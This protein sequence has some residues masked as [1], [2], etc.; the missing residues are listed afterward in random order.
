MVP[1]TNI[2]TVSDLNGKY[3]IQVPA[4]AKELC[5]SYAGGNPIC[6]SIDGNNT[7]NFTV[8]SQV[9]DEVV[10]TALGLKRD[11]AKLG[12]A[13]E[14]LGA[15]D[16]SD[17]ASTNFLDNLS[18]QFAGVNVLSGPTGVGSTS[19]VSIR[20]NASFGNN[21]PLYVVDGIPIDN[22]S[23]LNV[24]NE[25]SQGFQ[26]V[27]F[28][29]GSP[30][31]SPFDVESV[32]VLKG[33]ASAA[34][35]GTRAANGVVIINTKTGKPSEGLGI[36]VNSQTMFERPFRLPQF[37]NE[38][39]QGNGG[40][41]EYLNGAGGGVNDNISFSY[42]PRLD[43]GTLTPQ[44]DSPVQL[45]DG[46]I[47]RAGDLALYD[48]E[49]ISPT[50]FNSNPDNVAD[51]YETGVTTTNNIAL[52][53]AFSGGNYRLSFT[54]LRSDSYI[55][56]VN[57]E[58][59]NVSA[60][61]NFTPTKK[62]TVSTGINYVNSRSDNR[63]SSG[64]GSENLN[65]TLVSWLGRSTNLES[66]RDYWQ[67]GL[68]GI[69]QFSFNTSFFDNPFFILNENR[70]S[71][72]RDRFTG[73]LSANY[74]IS[75]KL[76]FRIRTGIDNS[77]EDREF[78]RAFS[79]NRFRNGAYAENTVN[80]T[81]QNTDVLLTYS[82]KFKGITFSASVGGNRLNQ[83]TEFE[84]IQAEALSAPG[85][86]RL[87]NTAVPLISFGQIT[88]RRI[89]SVYGLASV[90][91]RDQIFVDVT[92]RNDW[93]SSLATPESADNTSFF[94]PSVSASWIASK[95]LDLTRGPIS[96][97]QLRAS[98]AQVGSDTDPYRTTGT[99]TASTPVGGNPAF[100]SQAQLPA[101]GLRPERST[102]FEGGVDV[103]VLDDKIG[104][105]LTVYTQLNKD[106]ILNLPSPISSGYESRIV[107]GGAVRATGIEAVLSMRN[108]KLGPIRYDGRINFTKSQATVERLPDGVDR[109]TIDFARVYSSPGQT[110]FFIAEEGSKI[111]DIFGTGYLR[112]DEG[113]F[114]VDSDGEFIADNTLRKLGNYTPDFQV[115]FNNTFSYDRFS[116]SFLVDW[117]QGGELVSRT[118]A[119]GAYS[120]QL[121]ESSFR[122]E[123]GIIVP[124]VVN[125]GTADAPVF[126]ENTTAISAETF[127]IQFY[128]RENE[129]NNTLDATF[130]KL[131][132]IRLGYSLNSKNV[133]WL[134]NFEFA[135]IG[136]NLA[137]WSP[138]IRHFDP[139]QFAVQGT[140]FV[141]GVEDISY[142]TPRSIGFS[143][144]A[145]F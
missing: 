70:N 83:K 10:I 18:G 133:N 96:F 126:V 32:T 30:E 44:F 143:I 52:S 78:R 76:D 89:N 20:G 55:P 117:R 42:G 53:Q 87:T 54:D 7:L 74:E 92:G 139:E 22:R 33:P 73:F 6:Q 128:N 39:G 28:G 132:E 90:G 136:R 61:L 13:I 112:N 75:E 57:F 99:F 51:L 36:E 25:A 104:L 98:A 141:R 1:N 59:N 142:P 116:L 27:D 115:G 114:I 131:R 85:I 24:T 31:I 77:D 47:V 107:N 100:T 80:F 62:L 113:R 67:P 60:R 66:L 118:Q 106:Q 5:V 37:Q 49:A 29:G 69:Q 26:E 111:G 134:N 16:I 124:G 50:P 38:F 8:S 110:V 58:R 121:E 122:P 88:E 3:S 120:G 45:A 82:D 94:Y 41:F 71:F 17:V 91:W 11:N 129:E 43:Q 119:L 97:L 56:G 15:R 137:A 102:S 12:Y 145:K 105:D 125:T 34:L 144:N 64:Y 140:R 68:E 84:Q 21:T 19:L 135:I 81:E 4:D 138:G 103:R 72:T 40:A 127:Y 109:T 63:P 65:Y 48:G 86:Y 46:T 14:S 79:T 35:Y 9:L 2:G 95:T 101:N 93:S 123:E 23:V 130:V 108:I